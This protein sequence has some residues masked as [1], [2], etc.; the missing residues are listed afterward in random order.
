MGEKMIR[1]R[2]LQIALDAMCSY[3]QV[4]LDEEEMEA[5]DVIATMLSNLQLQK[6]EGK[7][8]VGNV[9]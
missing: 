5:I 3:N 4:N 2:A 9:E 6:R 8:K 7:E 1:I